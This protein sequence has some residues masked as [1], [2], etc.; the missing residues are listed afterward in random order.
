MKKLTLDAINVFPAVCTWQNIAAMRHVIAPI[1]TLFDERII[2]P[3]KTLTTCVQECAQ[4][5]A[6]AHKPTFL[7]ELL[8]SVVQ[9]ST[10][11]D[12]WKIVRSVR[13]KDG[14]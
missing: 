6:L 5:A 7:G 8:E 1:D 11:M 3:R 12:K 10:G 14:E 2:L 9:N 13:H 4:K